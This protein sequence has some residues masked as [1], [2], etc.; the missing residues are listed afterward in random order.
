LAVFAKGDV[1]VKGVAFAAGPGA[2]G[3]SVERVKYQMVSNAA[4]STA[5]MMTNGRAR[6]IQST[7]Y[8][9]R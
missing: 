1:P 5:A 9:C 8:E 6:F 7:D 2:G 3:L 4:T